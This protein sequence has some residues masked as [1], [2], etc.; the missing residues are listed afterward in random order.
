MT[1]IT[2]AF[3]NRILFSYDTLNGF[4]RITITDTLQ[5]QTVIS[6]SED[7]DGTIITTVD[8]PDDITLTYRTEQCTEPFTFGALASYTDAVGQTEHYAYTVKESNY[9]SEKPGTDYHVNLT[10]VTHPTGAQ[11]IYQYEKYTSRLK[12]H[13]TVS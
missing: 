10:T 1:E 2:D 6:S 9:S 13:P 5:R 11:T 8:L 12:D 4:D 3:D 7:T